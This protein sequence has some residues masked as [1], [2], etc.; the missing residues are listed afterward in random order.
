[1]NTKLFL[2]QWRDDEAR[3]LIREHN[4]ETAK[5]A[6][7]RFC[8]DAGNIEAMEDDVGE[9]NLCESI[10]VIEIPEVRHG[11]VIEWVDQTFT[12]VN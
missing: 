12:V 1:M 5:D 11:Q 3:F 9:G 8:E 2:I 4:E 6:F 7:I 10:S